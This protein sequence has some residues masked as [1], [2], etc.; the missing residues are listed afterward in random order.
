MKTFRYIGGKNVTAVKAWHVVMDGLMAGYAQQ[1]MAND[2]GLSLTAVQFAMQGRR[3]GRS[4]AQ[5]LSQ[6][7][8]V[9]VD[10]ILA[11]ELRTCWDVPVPRWALKE[12][13]A[14]TRS[15]IEV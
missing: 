1:T 7:T 9:G 3:A 13:S 2:A 5:A 4:V 11:C 8:G 12:M 6:L 15:H 14:E 10:L